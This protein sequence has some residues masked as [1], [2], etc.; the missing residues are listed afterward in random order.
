M[1][2]ATEEKAEIMRELPWPSVIYPLHSG[3]G[4]THLSRVKKHSV[5]GSLIF[6]IIQ[7]ASTAS[8]HYSL[9][10]FTFM[11]ELFVVLQVLFA[12][13]YFHW[14]NSTRNSR[15]RSSIQ[16]RISSKSIPHKISKTESLLNE[17]DESHL[18]L[19][20]SHPWA[21]SETQLCILATEKKQST[22]PPHHTQFHFMIRD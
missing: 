5:T 12:S 21:D 13:S 3:D 18:S 4:S 20:S 9:V 8:I 17:L 19:V 14:G 2:S 7:M 1:G 16:H 10:N 6:N 15:W 11:S 22:S